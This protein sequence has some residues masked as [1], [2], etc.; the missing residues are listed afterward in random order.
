MET[1][2]RDDGAIREGGGG[3]LFL[4]ML[5]FNAHYPPPELPILNLTILDRLSAEDQE[6][7]KRRHGV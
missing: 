2:G 7:V 3:V 6:K 1:D 5:S 4:F